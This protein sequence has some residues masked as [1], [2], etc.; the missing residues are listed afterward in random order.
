MS[1]KDTYDVIVI[2][3]GPAG[4]TAAGRAGERGLR[5]LLLEK[6]KIL[7][8]KLSITGG[9]R[10]NITN[11]EHDLRIFLSN[12][13]NAEKFLYSP[14]TQ[15]GVEETIQFF[16]NGGLDIIVE[17]RK[18][19]FPKTQKATDVTTFL[20]AYMAKHGVIVRTNTAVEGFSHSREGVT[21]VV[22]NVGTYTAKSFI[23]ACGGMSHTETGSTGE[24]IMWL[25]DIGHTVHTSNPNLVPVKVRDAWVK[26]LSGVVL[27]NV[28]ITCTQGSEKYTQTGDILCTHFGLSG[29]VILNSAYR[30]QKMLCSGLV[31]ATIDLFPKDDVG[32]LRKKLHAHFVV[33]ANKT[34]TNA[35]REWFPTGVVSALLQQFPREIR[36]QKIHSLTREIRHKLVDIMKKLSLTITGTM[37]YEHAIISDG[38]VDLRDINTRTMQSKKHRNLYIVGDMLH[39]NRPSGGYS[40]QLCWTTGWVAG[41]SVQK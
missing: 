18:R 27:H 30:I 3:G 4:M 22:T 29:P 5:V 10:C 15:F 21:G 13:G 24:G 23:I 38:G 26:K 14:F 12:Y 36:I 2:C 11:A 34:L 19:A 16:K 8:K 37:G 6:N 9:G 31:D 20:K 7:G 28:R 33:H 40:L 25:K 17:N 1:N 41:N 32:T 35:L 39:I